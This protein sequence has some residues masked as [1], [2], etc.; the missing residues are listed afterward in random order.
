MAMSEATVHC[1]LHHISD[2]VLGDVLN[3]RRFQPV[4]TYLL[5]EPHFAGAETSRAVVDLAVRRAKQRLV[6]S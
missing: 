1:S 3:A 4:A 5:V 2:E 6:D